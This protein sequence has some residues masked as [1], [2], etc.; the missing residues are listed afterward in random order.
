MSDCWEAAG[1]QRPA[2]V[3]GCVRDGLC[4]WSRARVRR[5]RETR[6]HHPKSLEGLANELTDPTA[7]SLLGRSV[8]RGPAVSPCWC[9]RS[10]GLPPVFSSPG[11]G[12]LPVSSCSVSAKLLGCCSPGLQLRVLTHG[13]QTVPQ[14]LPATPARSELPCLGSLGFSGQICPAPA[15]PCGW[16]KG[17]CSG[18]WIRAVSHSVLTYLCLSAG[19]RR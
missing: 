15:C 12:E 10:C 2:G 3:R 7:L 14:S 18:T 9:C 8:V 13:A 17:R 1:R 16:M 4:L 6:E 19:K 5:G 11:P